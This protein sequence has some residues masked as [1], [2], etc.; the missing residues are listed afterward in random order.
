[1]LDGFSFGDTATWDFRMHVEKL[2]K[3]VLPK[4][5]QDV[6][7]IPGRNGE[8]HASDGTFENYIQPYECYFHGEYPTPKMAH[9]IKSWLAS[10]GG[11]RRLQEVYDKEHFRL[12]VFS[13]PMDIANILNQY[14]RC[15]VNFN[16]A[17]QS[18]LVSGENTVIFTAAGILRNPTEFEAKPV[19]RVFGTDA[20]ELHV[21]GVTV[22]IDAFSHPIIIDCEAQNAYSEAEGNAVINQNGNIYAIPFPVLSAGEN[23]IEFEGGITK[24]EITPRWWEL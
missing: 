12:A 10:A 3:Q 16:C 13:G 15:T 20:G 6:F 2:P 18:F 1:M 4:S 11:Y 21:N 19:I 14:G 9:A 23:T 7:L 17:P 8:L 24:V 22:R 5:R